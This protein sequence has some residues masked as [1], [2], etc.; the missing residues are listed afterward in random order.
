MTTQRP[1]DDPGNPV[2]AAMTGLAA[3][4][5]DPLR[6]TALQLL[7]AEGPHTLSQL[8]DALAVSPSRLGNHLG[9]LR[10]AGLV[11]VERS[12]RHAV[13][14]VGRPQL[15]PLLEAL[16][17]YA[18]AAG[19]APGVRAPGPADI[20][21]TC[22]DH[23]AGRLGVAV[24]RLLVDRG[25]LGQPD[26]A[27]DELAL[28]GDLSA[29]AELGVEPARLDAG[30]LDAGRRKAA[31][32]C[33]DRSHRV[34]HLGGALGAAVLSSLLAQELVATRP[35][36]RELTITARGRERLPVLVPGFR[37]VP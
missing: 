27:G 35:G 33:L 20:A 16:A 19:A 36:S 30:R 2:L 1:W 9:R 10:A 12:G 29:L 34:P 37:P 26:G 6:L 32:A 3:E 14:R 4:L 28:G 22:Y 11:S 13:Y 17:A 5:A 31:T 24:L 23:L 8:A 15:P 21:H 7:A 18:H 25:A